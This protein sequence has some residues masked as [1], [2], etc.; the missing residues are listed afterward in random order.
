MA[1]GNCL[2][3]TFKHWL[4][5]GGTVVI[6]WRPG[7]GTFPHIALQGR[8]GR[9]WAAEP[10]SDEN[11]TMLQTLWYEYDWNQVAVYNTMESET[12][13]EEPR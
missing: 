6:R 13:L 4:Q 8:G 2:T 10:R 3:A 9:I 12:D 5:E 11:R 7:T 1:K